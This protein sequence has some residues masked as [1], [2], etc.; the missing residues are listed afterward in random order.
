ME[1]KLK[2][3]F[4]CTGN[5]ARSVLCEAY[6]NAKGAG[7]FRAFSAGSHPNGAVNYRHW[8]GLVQK[9]QDGKTQRI[10]AKVVQAFEDYRAGRLGT[11][12]AVHNAPTTVIES[13]S[14][15]AGS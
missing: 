13:R 9:S 4:L 1:R 14:D 15:G 5:S 7:G 8:L 11:I 2:V 12:P 10:P 6:L 3:L